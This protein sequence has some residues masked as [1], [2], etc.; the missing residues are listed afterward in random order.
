[1]FLKIFSVDFSEDR[2]LSNE[3]QSATETINNRLRKMDHKLSELNRYWLEMDQTGQPP[4]VTPR[5]S[6]SAYQSYPLD[7]RS[8]T[9]PPKLPSQGQRSQTLP[10]SSRSTLGPFSRTESMNR[11]DIPKTIK[12]GPI[13]KHDSDRRRTVE[14]K[15][16][17]RSR[18]SDQ[19]D[20]IISNGHS[21]SE[22]QV[23]HE[24]Y[25]AMSEPH[26]SQSYYPRSEDFVSHIPQSSFSYMPTAD[27]RSASPQVPPGPSSDY[28]QSNNEPMIEDQ[29]IQP[30]IYP[31]VQSQYQSQPAYQR[32]LYSTQADPTSLPSSSTHKRSYS[33]IQPEV[34]N[35]YQSQPDLN[36]P[37]LTKSSVQEPKGSSKYMVPDTLPVTKSTP[38]LSKP[39]PGKVEIMPKF[40]LP[41]RAE[42]PPKSFQELLTKFQTGETTE[43]PMESREKQEVQ[44]EISQVLRSR[45]SYLD[46]EDKVLDKKRTPDLQ[47]EMEEVRK[48]NLNIFCPSTC[49]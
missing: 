17:Q 9:L 25:V 32:S 41:R 15:K 21:A 14:L 26:V 16:G 39:P 34:S 37:K 42:S 38:D 43:K 30:D 8:S 1:M 22:P 36:E 10:I 20:G 4:S 45:A 5:F 46:E 44:K 11:K 19:S 18:P 24:P 31:S 29:I 28:R 2:K 6:K 23:R 3:D 33:A 49:N 47:R 40:H 27:R 48:N 7:Q 12:K 13:S 35:T